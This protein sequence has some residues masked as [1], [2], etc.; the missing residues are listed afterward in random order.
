MANISFTDVA[1][2]ELN[3][4]IYGHAKKPVNCNNGMV[5]GGGTVYPEVNLTLPT[6][7]INEETMPKVLSQ[8]EEMIHGICSK[9]YELF[10]PGIIIEIELLP[11][12]TFNPQWGVDVTKVVKGVMKEY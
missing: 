9:A 12:C 4:F 3:E 11:P 8:Y 7:L 10:S 2:T 6:M 5:I 1:Y